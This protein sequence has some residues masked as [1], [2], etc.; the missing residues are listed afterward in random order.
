MNGDSCAGGWQT[1]GQRRRSFRG[2]RNCVSCGVKAARGIGAI[3]VAIAES[4]FADLSPQKGSVHRL[5]PSRRSRCNRLRH[6]PRSSLSARGGESS[7]GS[8]CP[9]P[10]HF[11]HA[12]NLFLSMWKRSRGA[13]ESLRVELAVMPNRSRLRE[14]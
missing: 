5:Q 2:R 10:H 13:R 14:D 3:I 7:M 1:Q 6:R 12:H 11:A 9:L 8:F 4:F